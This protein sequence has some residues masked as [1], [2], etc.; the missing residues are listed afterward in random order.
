[1]VRAL[2]GKALSHAVG[3]H[4]AAAPRSQLLHRDRSARAALEKRSRTQRAQTTMADRDDLDVGAIEDDALN[5]D[6][7]ENEDEVEEGYKMAKVSGCVEIN[8]CVGCTTASCRRRSYLPC[9]DASTSTST[10][11]GFAT[12]RGSRSCGTRR[13]RSASTGPISC[14]CS[15]AFLCRRPRRSAT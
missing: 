2:L 6:D 10:T 7:D 9:R 5:E 15:L 8:Q 13:S 14:P 1:M 11:I 12:R 4:K 3:A